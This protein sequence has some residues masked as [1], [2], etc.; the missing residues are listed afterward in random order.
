MAMTT[1]RLH[2][3]T[4]GRDPA[5]ATGTGRRQLARRG[6]HAHDPDCSRR[7]PGPAGREKCPLGSAGGCRQRWNG[8]PGYAA[9]PPG[10]STPP[11]AR[12]RRGGRSQASGVRWPR[13]RRRVGVAA[14]PH[15]PERSRP[16]PSVPGTVPP[17]KPRSRRRAG[18][19]EPHAPEHRSPRASGPGSHADCQAGSR[20][21]SAAAKPHAPVPSNP[22]AHP[23]RHDWM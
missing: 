21:R 3:V 2:G 17:A 14:E 11:T 8:A 9:R 12:Y 1:S 16:R 19:T 23:P 5:R 10:F 13:L 4:T 20:R 15:A 7:S 22:T 18:A 6:R